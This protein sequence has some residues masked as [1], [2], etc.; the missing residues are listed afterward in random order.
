VNWLKIILI[1]NGN[2]NTTTTTTTL[3]PQTHSV[4]VTTL[5][6]NFKQIINRSSG[7]YVVNVYKEGGP[8][9]IFS[10]AKASTDSQ[11]V[12][13]CSLKIDKN[14]ET[15][16]LKWES[17]WIELCV[18]GDNAQGEYTVTWL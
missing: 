11:P 15:I 18:S 3:P 14:G 4:L 2:T 9:K 8:C 5:E 13:N 1:P 12:I 6:S 17:N 7:A 16:N 10:I